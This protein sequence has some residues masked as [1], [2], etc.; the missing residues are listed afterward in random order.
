MACG[1]CGGG[2]PRQIKVVNDTSPSQP[3]NI[4][5]LPVQRQ[6]NNRINRCGTCSSLTMLVSINGKERT[7]CVNP[8]CR[9]VQ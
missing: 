9:L 3:L 7:Q 6:I 2:A 1:S 8:A 4:R 5:P